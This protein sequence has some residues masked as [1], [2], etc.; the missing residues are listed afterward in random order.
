MTEGEARAL[1]IQE[2]DYCYVLARAWEDQ[3]KHGICL[4]RIYTKG[5]CEEI[6]MAWWKNGQFQ[7]RPADIDVVNWVRLFENAVSEGVFTADERLGMLQA[8]VR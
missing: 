3:E 1:A 2:T 4:E 7:T 8:L 5:R 6:R